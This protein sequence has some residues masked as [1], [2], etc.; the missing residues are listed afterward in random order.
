MKVNNP[1]EPSDNVINTK[2]S[3]NYFQVNFLDEKWVKGCSLKKHKFSNKYNSFEDMSKAIIEVTT[4]M[5]I[6]L[7]KHGYDIL[8][9][10]SWFHQH[11]HNCHEVTDDKKEV[12]HDII[13]NIYGD[14]LDIQT[15]SDNKIL[16]QFGINQGLRIVCLYNKA[17]NILYPLFIDPFHLIHESIKHNEG[18]PMTNRYCA[19]ELVFEKGN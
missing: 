10:N 18:D 8:S 9:K 19:Y 5:M 13:N 3:N 11:K 4:T 2:E 1:I 7:Q 16:W 15:D 14:S 12:V 17:T 6:F